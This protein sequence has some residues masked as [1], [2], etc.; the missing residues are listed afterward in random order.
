VDETIEY[1][2]FYGAGASLTESSAAVLDG[3]N[4]ATRADMLQ[5][6]FSN[7]TGIGLSLLR[8][9]MGSSD[10]SLM[11]DTYWDDSQGTFSID[12]DPI[13]QSRCHK[14]THTYGSLILWSPPAMKTSNR[15]KVSSIT[16][17]LTVRWYISYQFCSLQHWH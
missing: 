9:P 14:S 13:A 5:A 17:G 8:Q 6:L 4:A 11:H 1:Q 7:D 2:T 15:C 12:G 16:Q 3:V 10:F